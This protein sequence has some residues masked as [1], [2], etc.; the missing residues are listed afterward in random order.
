MQTLTRRDLLISVTAAG[1]GSTLGIGKVGAQTVDFK[2]KTISM[3]VGYAAGGGAD[4]IGRLVAP[5]LTRLLPG[6]PVVTV[7]NMPGASGGKAMSFVAQKG[8]NDGTL[9]MMGS[10]SA[11]DPLNYRTANLPYKPEEFNIVAGF[12]RGGLALIVNTAALSRLN[13]TSKPPVTMGAITAHDVFGRSGLTLWGIECLG[14]NVKWVIG[15]AGTNDVL[16]ALDRGEVDMAITGDL[17]KIRNQVNTGKIKILALSGPRAEMQDVPQIADQVIDKIDDPLE[18]KAFAYWRNYNTLDK[19]IALPPNTDKAVV[20]AYRAACDEMAKD[21]QFVQ[22]GKSMS[23]DF[24]IQT[25]D[26]VAASIKTLAETPDEAINFIKTIA[27]KQG[28]SMK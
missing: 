14:W 24:I 23:E 20:A 9:L 8:T 21:P 7:Q 10:G 3:V 19:W 2:G 17:N 11:V 16:I 25:P 28:L 4:L 26:Q 27:A 6:N 15:Y 22:A 5:N 18:K 12:G 13:D 1:I